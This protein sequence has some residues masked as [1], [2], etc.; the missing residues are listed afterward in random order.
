MITAQQLRPCGP[1]A[2][3]VQLADL[4]AVLA[5][6]ATLRERPTPELADV[7]DVVPGAETVL[8]TIAGT[9]LAR[10]RSALLRLDPVLPATAGIA[11]EIE[12]P[13]HYDG[14]DLAEVA[15]LAGLTVAEII[16][17][18]TT[19]PWRAG[20]GGFAPGFAYLVDGDERLRLPR[21]SSPRTRVPAG[22]VALGGG[23]CA[24]YPRSS[25]GGWHLIGHTD[26]AVWDTD[27]DPA[28]LIVPG[29]AVRFR[30]VN[31]P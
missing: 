26:L 7:V 23:Y 29:A 18:H 8:V 31:A 25:P 14:P 13:V 24:V 9:D 4:A 17:A 5:L 20:F 21:R 27:R 6:A 15:A 11:P 19:I 16:T 10:L 22:S 28:A 1:H 12:I 30:D 3:L 2:I